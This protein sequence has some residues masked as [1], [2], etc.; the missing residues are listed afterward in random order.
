MSMQP[1]HDRIL[2]LILGALMAFGP[3]SIDL[4]LPS[5]PFIA[6]SFSVSS[7][8]VELS[9]ASFFIGLALGQL[10]YGP[11]SDHLG[12]RPTVLLGLS[13]YAIASM[14]CAFTQSLELLIA[15]RFIQALGACA[16]IVVARAVVRDRFE[17]QESA[18][19]LSML[20]LVMGAAPILAP[21]IGGAVSQ[22]AGWRVLFGLLAAG[23]LICW[24][25]V[26]RLMPETRRVSSEKPRLLQAV[27]DR[28]FVG[29]ALAGG[30]A[31]AG[32]FAYIT[33][34]PF[35]FIELFGIPSHHF[36]WVFGTN[37]VALIAS[38][39][40][41]RWLLLRRDVKWVLRR[42]FPALAVVGSVLVLAGFLGWGFWGVAAPLWAYVGILGI[43]YPN[44][45]AVALQ[46]QG[47]QS[48]AASAWL[49]VFQFSLATGAAWL[50][51]WLH[52]GS[53]LAMSTVVG[54]C[55]VSSLVVYWHWHGHMGHGHMGS[56]STYCISA[57]PSH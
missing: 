36:G 57:E 11:L 50:V 10:L 54:G 23:S 33:G 34:S 38:S 49:G 14:A 35:V 27:R 55:G 7:A 37:A 6:A 43:T 16:G 56:N 28:G 47:A 45:T 1:D 15:A 13:V 20:M 31:Y 5:F 30:L 2:V 29:H 8:R 39:Q 24:V 53:P 48:G 17:A 3:L 9:L 25:V 18:R 4:Y 41:N 26:F 19:V 44:T 21:L 22:V 46:G 51:S 52:D 32:M 12:R 42:A 40:F